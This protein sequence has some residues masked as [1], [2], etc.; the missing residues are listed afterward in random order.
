MEAESAA[1]MIV[2]VPVSYKSILI[3][4]WWCL[5]PGLSIFLNTC[6]GG[7]PSGSDSKESACN[8]GDSGSVPGS[9]RSP[10]EVNGYPCQYS[11]LGNW[12][13][14]KSHGQRS[15]AGYSAW[16]CKESDTTE[17]LALLT[18]LCFGQMFIL[19][20]LSFL[21]NK[22]LRRVMWRLQIK[23]WRKCFLDRRTAN[24]KA[25]VGGWSL[26]CLGAYRW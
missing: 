25:L 1:Q 3:K 18:N 13:K 11:C 9:G 15:L 7:F 20:Y 21:I 23:V 16:D 22:S 4:K 5:E 2:K 19:S 26:V 24:K 8:A 12:K 17:Q 14:R 10:G 6:F